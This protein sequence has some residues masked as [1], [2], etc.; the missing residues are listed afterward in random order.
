MSFASR[1]EAGVTRG[2]R[3]ITARYGWGVADQSLSSLTNFALGVL[4]A[5]TLPSANFGAFALVFAAYVIG[6]GAARAITSEPFSIR[7][8]AVSQ[9]EWK[10]GAALTSGTALVVG[11]VVGLSCILAALIVGGSLGSGLVALG[12][13][14]P[15]LLLQ[16]TWRFI[17]FSRSRGAAA[18]SNDLFWAVALFVGVTILLA[19]GA[20]SVGLLVL[21]WGGA[22]TL[23]GLFG[24]LQTSVLPLPGRSLQWL[25]E[26][27]DLVPRFLGELAV[28]SVVGQVTV[29]GLGAIAGLA[30]AGALRAGQLL[31]GPLNVLYLGLSVVAVP[32]GVRA[33]RVSARRLLRICRR[34]SVFFVMC[35]LGLGTAMWALP[36]QMGTALLR[37]NWMGAHRV[38]LPL[39][40]A[41]AGFGAVLGAG[42]GLRAL[43]AARLSLRARLLVAPLSLMGGLGG[44]A[45]SGATGAAWGLA[46]AAVGGAG[47]W[48]GYFLRGL[49]EHGRGGEEPSDHES[50]A[51]EEVDMRIENA[52][53]P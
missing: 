49:R 52:P 6:L 47:V 11:V 13:T 51:L 41:M 32:E 4:A 21:I 39:A 20:E 18:F 45:T 10:N 35:A 44:A 40:V 53:S 48:W 1:S 34:L 43:A 12:A 31:L 26:Q 27:K 19:T 25:R 22:G 17:L 16:D 42:I 50:T 2:V 23:A 5:R 9:A 24:L 36:D 38:V 46:L 33:L 30:E 15:G 3:S 8:S 28:M 29:F 37:G 7:F 14:M